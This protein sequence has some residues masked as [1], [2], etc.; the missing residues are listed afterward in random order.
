MGEKA[1]WFN[2]QYNHWMIGSSKSQVAEMFTEN[3]FGGLTDK[4][5]VWKYWNN[6]W[7]T[8]KRNDI[9][10]QCTSMYLITAF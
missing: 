9:S 8:S 1:I 10:L 5:N 2:A 6:E 3:K 4:R 7:K